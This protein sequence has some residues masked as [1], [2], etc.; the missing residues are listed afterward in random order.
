MKVRGKEL[1]GPKPRIIAIPRDQTF[2]PILKDGK[3]QVGEDNLPLMQPVCNDVI[4]Q[5]RVVQEIDDFD[6]IL[7][8]PQPKTVTKPSG[9]TSKN[10]D[11]PEYIRQLNEWSVKRTHWVVLKALTATEG[12]EWDTVDMNDPDTWGNY[13][14]DLKEAGFNAAEV[15]R[16]VNGALST[17]SIDEAKMEEARARFLAL[18][19]R[20]KA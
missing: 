15:A 7:P 6:T 2:E 10:F 5:A 8:P 1:Q 19:A 14:N 11:D 18:E 17:N 20:L 16:V 13:V 9:E 4:F 3:A 12:L